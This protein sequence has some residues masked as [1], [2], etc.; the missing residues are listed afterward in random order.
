MQRKYISNRNIIPLNLYKRILSIMPIC[1]VDA[2]FKVRKEVYLFKRSY[3]PAKFE[4]WVIGGRITKGECIQDAIIR[5]VKEE[6]G[7]DV[8]IVKKVGVYELFFDAS[9]FTNKNKM[10]STHAIS[11]C[12]VVEP[13]N[14]NF[15]LKLNNEYTDYLK[16]TKIDNKF[17]PYIKKVLRESMVL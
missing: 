16:I 13:K 9:R 15:K 6:V 5:K 8:S 12:F 2:I 4:W 3:H 14:K 17:H 10:I 7:V 11:N 1:C